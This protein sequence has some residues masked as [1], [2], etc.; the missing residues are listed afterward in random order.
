MSN[1]IIEKLLNGAEVEW[2]PLG[3]VAELKRGKT[4]TAKDKTEG[5]I[6]VISGGQKPAY[7]TG[8]YNREGETITIAG[9]GAYAGFLMYWNE[10]IFLGDAFSVKPDLDILITKYVYHFLLSKQQWIFNLK[11]GSGVPHVYPKDLAILEI[12]IPPLEIQQKIVKTLDKFTELEATLEAELAL[13]KKQ[14][15]YYRETLLTFPQDLDRGGYNDI[16]KA[17]GQVVGK[18]AHPTVVWK[19]LGEIGEARMCKRILKEQTSNVGDI[20]FYKI[21]TFGKKPNA[22]ISRELFEDYKQKY[23]YPRKGN[24][25]IS[26]S[27]TIGRTVIFDGED[28]YFQDSNI[29][30]IEND[31]SQ[32][33]DKF[34]FYLYQI[35]D[36]NIAEGGTIQRLY[37]DNLKKLKIPVPPLSEQQKIVNIL[38]KFDSLTNSITE[39]LPKEIKLRREQYGYYREQLL[40]FPKP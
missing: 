5:N 14:Y 20:P 22:Y 9:S 4:I 29:V 12:P 10:P 16:T 15:Q 17:I 19:S 11:K 23:S 8:E 40:N 36:W 3:E 26:A 24:I 2:K 38:D 39:G 25:L 34:L 27:G 1:S 35:A 21:G 37:N 32:V 13:R 7:Y 31:E 30:W 33:L 28:S 6:P 18:N